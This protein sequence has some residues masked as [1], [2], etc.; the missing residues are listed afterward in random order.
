MA[1]A[2]SR[3]IRDLGG[4]AVLEPRK[5]DEPRG[6]RP[7]L[8]V[9]LE[10]ERYNVD[11]VISHPMAASHAYEAECG[12]LAVAQKAAAAKHAKHAADAKAAGA[13]FVAFSL[14]STGG[15]TMEAS[16]FVSTVLKQTKAMNA[17][18]CPREVVKGLHGVIAMAVVRDN[19]RAVRDCARFG[20]E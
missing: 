10:G 18:W 1:K 13:E 3:W 8:R 6:R 5:P 15:W 11:V 17:R 4:I 2:L 12:S 7:D 19:A 20:G 16:R 9:E 14:E